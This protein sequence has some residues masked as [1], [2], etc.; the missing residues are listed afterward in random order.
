MQ[1]WLAFTM[2]SLVD[3]ELRGLRETAHEGL[4]GLCRTAAELVGAPDEAAAERLHALVDG[5]ALHA[6]ADPART[7]PARI[8]RLLDAEL[9]ELQ[10]RH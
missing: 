7:T 10:R 2:R 6:V 8:A 4:R 1:V 5:L 3:P 9:D